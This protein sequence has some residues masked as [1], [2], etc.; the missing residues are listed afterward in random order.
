L[1]S[2]VDTDVLDSPPRTIAKLGQLAAAAMT[3]VA[4]TAPVRDR[5]DPHRRRARP[6][7][8][9]LAARLRDRH[10]H[11]LRR[12]AELVRRAARSRDPRSRLR[13]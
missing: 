9:K 7:T 12:L 2:S 1:T 6:H 10:A 13:S 5:D 4:T 8:E 3:S 11:R